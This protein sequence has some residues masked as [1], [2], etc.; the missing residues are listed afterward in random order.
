MAR[1]ISGMVDNRF[2]PFVE[3]MNGLLQQARRAEQSIR[4]TNN[5]N[6]TERGDGGE[7][8]SSAPDG[9]LSDHLL[10]ASRTELDDPSTTL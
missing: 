1:V 7:S 8:G 3:A 2:N 4:T 10:T 5:F 9:A 6:V